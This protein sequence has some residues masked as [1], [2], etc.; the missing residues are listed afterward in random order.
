MIVLYSTVPPVVATAWSKATPTGTSH[1]GLLIGTLVS[2]VSSAAS[3]T[4]STVESSIR[5]VLESGS[6]STYYAL[7]ATGSSGVVRYNSSS[8]QR[9]HSLA[10]ATSGQTSSFTSSSGGTSSSSSSG[11]S[12]DTLLSADVSWSATASSTATAS[13]SGT[14]FLNNA[15]TYATATATTVTTTAAATRTISTRTSA[16]FVTLGTLAGTTPSTTQVTT[17]ATRTLWTTG[18]SAS[19]RT[20]STVFT[21][22]LLGTGLSQSP[23][24]SIVAT[25]YAEATEWLWRLASAVPT[26]AGLYAL[27]D[28]MESAISAGGFETRDAATFSG[29]RGGSYGVATYVTTTRTEAC[30]AHA[31]T[32]STVARTIRTLN[33]TTHGTTTTANQVL[34]TRTQG[35][36][37]AETT[38]TSAVS[39][40]W[41]AMTTQ[42]EALSVAV[43]TT[44]AGIVNDTAAGYSVVTTTLRARV[45]I[46][47]QVSRVVAFPADLSAPTPG[48]DGTVS[49]TYTTRGAAVVRFTPKE[50]LVDYAY[51]RAAHVAAGVFRASAAAAATDA[52]Y[53]DF[54]LSAAPSS[55]YV[56][57]SH[58]HPLAFGNTALEQV[59]P[60]AAVGGTVGWMA[61]RRSVLGVNA[62]YLGAL[63]FGGRSEAAAPN[64][65]LHGPVVGWW[66]GTWRASDQVVAT[67]SIPALP[68]AVNVPTETE[69]LWEN[70]AAR[71]EYEAGGIVMGRTGPDAVYVVTEKRNA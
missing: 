12:Y 59:I 5:S 7:T 62:P 60:D 70:S 64:V 38:T 24:V 67:T 40:T 3:H 17:Q 63:F 32:V 57:G 25:S 56:V 71:F 31:V 6:G 54:T 22:W 18:G 36:F 28:V 43:S 30:T 44:R 42:W 37:W 55:V 48:T 21:T 9:T 23:F 61:V 1:A 50:S 10:V 65:L 49:F 16:L 58:A 51:F 4:V 29:T 45:F 39:V 11:I 69:L 46:E 8:E 27:S 26:A 47:T 35:T 33:Q 20:V 52:R 34:T 41:A 19:D 53:S 66:K 13:S 2:V 68:G 15:N 14:A